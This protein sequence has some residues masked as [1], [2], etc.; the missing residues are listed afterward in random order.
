MHNS[1]SL[2]ELS[3]QAALRGAMVLLR[4]ANFS[5]SATQG[6]AKEG[7]PYAHPLV[8]C[9]LLLAQHKQNPQDNRAR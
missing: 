2:G 3:E 6:E 8:S 9:S 1:Y 5:P 4:T 7:I